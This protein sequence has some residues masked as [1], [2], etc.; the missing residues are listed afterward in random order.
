[1]TH[2]TRHELLYLRIMAELGTVCQSEQT[3]NLSYTTAGTVGT[4]VP[5]H[6]VCEKQHAAF[7]VNA[8]VYLGSG[9]IVYAQTNVDTLQ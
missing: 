6:Q 7:V 3:L 9:S 8:V 4:E 5:A 2:D 1:M